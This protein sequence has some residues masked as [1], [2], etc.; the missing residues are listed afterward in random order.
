MLKNH[1]PRLSFDEVFK[2]T[3]IELEL[4]T[5]PEMILLMERGIRSGVSQCLNIYAKVNKR[6]MG[7]DSNPCEEDFYIMDLDINSQYGAALSQ[8]IPYCGF[9]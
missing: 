4:L 1:L 5:D 6:F 8:L 7:S 2:Y 3:R 9:I